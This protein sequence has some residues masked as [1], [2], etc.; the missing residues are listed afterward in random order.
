[1]RR[2]WLSS[3][4]A[5]AFAFLSTQHHNL[6]MLLLALGLGSAGTSV[7]T[8]VPLVRTAMLVV[9]LAMAAA[10]GYQ[11]ARP[12][13]PAAMRLIGALSIFFTLGLAGWSVLRFGL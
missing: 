13:R 10:I 12:S 5:V 4:A 2:E 3:F 1:M 6:M 11:I 7:M 9:S 8:Q